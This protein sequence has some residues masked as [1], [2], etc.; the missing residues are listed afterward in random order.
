MTW[1]WHVPS[2]VVAGEEATTEGA[3]L[4]AGY[5]RRALLVT[6]AG[7]RGQ[8]LLVERW[9]S[10]LAA[11]GV[12]VRVHDRVESA[13]TISGIR[14][15]ADAVRDQ[16]AD[17]VVAVGGG[18]VMDSAKVAA[19][20]V[21][22]PSVLC[23]GWEDPGGLL[24]PVLRASRRALPCIAAPA[25]IGTGSEVSPSA[26]VRTV[27]TKKLVVHAGLRPTV[28]VLDP[29]A[30]ATTPRSLI[31]EGALEILLRSVGPLV[32]ESH[33][34]P[35]SDRVAAAVARQVI[36]DGELVST[37]SGASDDE[38]IAA[39]HRLALASAHTH[40]GWLLAGRDSFG[41][42]LWYLANETAVAL[43]VTKMQATAALLPNYLNY[44]GRGRFPGTSLVRVEQLAKLLTV[45]MA[46]LPRAADE[47]LARWN[48]PRC[49]GEIGGRRDVAG[50]LARSTFRAWGPPHRSLHGFDLGLLEE[51]Y[52]DATG[53]IP[54]TR[55][56]PFQSTIKPMKEVKA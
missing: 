4:A 51:F 46:D 3:R 34:E 5:G 12:T 1:S 44:L 17:L 33:A 39:R 41:H 10:A 26:S 50:G 29:A 30:T 7:I 49:L 19:L 20:A 54:T 55:A 24:V 36:H 35:F 16:G 14:A 9:C 22:Q 52:S 40:T 15:L 6:D 32:G 13:P 47:L 23:D 48:L 56:R 28:A 37:R 2:I 25:T 38:E 45:A 42:K 53:R 8:T 27:D 18:S 11:N 31:V 43:G 21:R